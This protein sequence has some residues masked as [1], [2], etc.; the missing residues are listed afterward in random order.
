MIFSLRK[1]RPTIRRAA[2]VRLARKI[3]SALFVGCIF[4]GAVRAQTVPLVELPTPTVITPHFVPAPK[5]P[6]V[7]V[8][9][10][11]TNVPALP[12]IEP[13]KT[14]AIAPAQ[15]VTEDAVQSFGTTEL[16]GPQRLFKRESERQ[17]FE[18]IAQDMKKQIG[19]GKAIFPEE[20]IISKEP[21]RPR[22]FP[23]LVKQVEPSYLCHGRLYFEQPNF[24]RTGYDFRILQPAIC[25]GVFYYDLALLPYHAWTDLQDRTE[26]SV[27]KCLP[28]DP[29]PLLLPR[30]R[31]SVTGL[32]GFTGTA[33][34]LGLLFPR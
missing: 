18:R 28:G 29:A 20:P 2:P 24:E 6:A 13:K 32:V 11:G 12:M 26:C 22:E 25:L 4:L 34:G 14:P 1:K 3:T 21:F 9:A 16:P 31:F 33:V 17:F 19:A 23:H 7:V 8:P 10:S 30:E 5:A 15:S 27:G